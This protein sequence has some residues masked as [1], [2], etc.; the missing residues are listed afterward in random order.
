VNSEAADEGIGA[1]D[2]EL[3]RSLRFHRFVEEHRERALSLA[4]RLLGSDSAA[5]EDVVQDAFVR[6]YRGLARFREDAKLSTWYYR[7]LV[8]EVRR[9]QRW[10]SLLEARRRLWASAEPPP[11]RALELREPTLRPRIAAALDVL[12]RGQREAFVMVHLESF[13]VREVAEALG[14]SEGTIKSHLHRALRT[15]R[16]ELAEV[17]KE[18]S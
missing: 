4:W 10:R 9:H 18:L 11:N 5:A 1:I 16:S 6:A 13:S 17:W 3:D 12:S 14:K 2:A 15:L 8:R 7:I